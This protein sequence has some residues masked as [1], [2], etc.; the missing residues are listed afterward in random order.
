MPKEEA[1]ASN[2]MLPWVICKK[3]LQF[4]GTDQEPGD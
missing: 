3:C 2:W 1:T 4:D